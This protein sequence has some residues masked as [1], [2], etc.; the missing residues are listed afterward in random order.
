MVGLTG[1]RVRR[2][3]RGY[4]YA[5]GE[6]VRDQPPVV[7]GAGWYYASF[8]D[9]VDLL[10][11]K[12]FLD[13]GLSLQ[14]VRRA[15]DEAR[16]VL[17]TEHFARETFF[18]DGSDV[19]LQLQEA[20]LKD[21]GDAILEL[22]SGG[23]WVIAPVI[24]ELAQQIDF[25]SPEGLASRWYPLGR[26]KPVVLDPKLSFGAPSIVH[27]G[28]KTVNVDDLFIAEHNS[29]EAVRAWWHLTDAEIQAAVDFEHQLRA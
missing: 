4:Q 25:Q 28:V 6:S 11:V 29:F 15:L 18:T 21:S 14:K 24:R 20:G 23:Q 8:L 10:F 27:R 13:H 12:R 16:R 9:L 5:Y 19:F 2:W 17:G 26:S 3:L 7:K 22:L 1:G